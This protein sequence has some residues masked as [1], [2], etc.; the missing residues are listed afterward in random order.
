MA[1]DTT[2]S[3]TYGNPYGRPLM[4]VITGNPAYSRLERMGDIGALALR[5][6]AMVIQPPFTWLREAIVQL[7]IYLRRCSIPFVIAHSVY[8]IG[9]GILLIGQ[10]TQVLGASDRFPAFIYIVWSREI[11][12]WI[13]AMI[14]AGVV[15]SAVTADL[16]ARKIRE[17]LDAL[18]VLG[19]KRERTLVV[20]RV[21]AMTVAMPVLAVLSFLLVQIIDYVMAPPLVHISHGVVRDIV[22][23]NIIAS[24]FYLTLILKNAILGFFFGIIACYKGLSCRMGAEG[25]GKAVNETVV[26]CFFSAWLFNSLF[27]LA[28]LTLFP[29]I[30]TPAG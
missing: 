6:S 29:D 19:V 5:T 8:L 4:E 7:S 2:K 1:R 20:P 22:A 11:S 30:A 17:E 15:G 23:N 9:F 16:G 12:T 14:F 26:I 24:D 3:F 21:V 27:N 13:T 28:Y 18:A 25:V 10:V